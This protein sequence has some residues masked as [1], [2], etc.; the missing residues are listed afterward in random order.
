MATTVLY[1]KGTYEVGML[2][3]LSEQNFLTWSLLVNM[4]FISALSAGW[5]KEFLS[6]E[7]TYLGC[8]NHCL[9]SVLHLLAVGSVI[10]SCTS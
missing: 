9:P 4:V 10:H 5:R 1:P 3:N 8:H 7:P 6:F 2:Y